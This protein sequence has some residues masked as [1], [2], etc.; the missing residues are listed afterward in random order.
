MIME[1]TENTHAPAIK[2]PD[3]A[4]AGATPEPET[5]GAVASAQE[6]T[7]TPT[8]AIDTTQTSTNHNLVK[9]Q[10]GDKE[11][12]IPRQYWDQIKEKPNLE[13]LITANT[14][15]RKKMSEQT[16]TIPDEYKFELGDNEKLLTQT[17]GEGE[18]K[19]NAIA[20]YK[21]IVSGIA[22]DA[23]L[24]QEQFN[25]L[26]ASM[27]K[28]E[29]TE[30]EAGRQAYDKDQNDIRAHLGGEAGLKA[31]VANEFKWANAV[32]GDNAL[33]TEA[34]K[35]MVDTPGGVR[36]LQALKRTV[37]EPQMPKGDN[38]EGDI[39]LTKM[40]VDEILA[41]GKHLA[42]P[43]L[44]EKVNSYYEKQAKKLPA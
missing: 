41:T 22:K 7:E 29:T 43:D 6:T 5:G 34:V 1:N 15:L 8:P 12:M 10:D 31:F 11:V 18:N 40:E 30:A 35:E 3:F 38:T 44:N 21:E 39:G 26:T 27:L 24:S 9:F 42:N 14:D 19:D 25:N 16:T 28:V 32:A 23:N 33:M 36:L 17:F 37:S 20:K 4:P 2:L 13:A